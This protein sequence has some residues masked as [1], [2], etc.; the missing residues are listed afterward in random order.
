MICRIRNYLAIGLL[1]VVA[2]VHVPLVKRT[3]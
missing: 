1:A 3:G 2:L